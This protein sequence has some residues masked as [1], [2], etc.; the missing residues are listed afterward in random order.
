MS[1]NF[2]SFT[3]LLVVCRFLFSIYLPTSR[4]ANFLV[5]GAR[6]TP[7]SLHSRHDLLALANA[8]KAHMLAIQVRCLARGD[9]ELTSCTG[10]EITSL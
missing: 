4:N 3:V 2:V 6:A 1:S 7:E 10:G 8:T 9:E 5:G